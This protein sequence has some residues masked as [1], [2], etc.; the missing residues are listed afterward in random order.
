M[1]Q[2]TVVNGR[3][4]VVTGAASGIGRALAQRLAGHGCPV[5]IC[6]WDEAGLEETAASISGPVLARRLDVSDRHGTPIAPEN[7]ANLVVFDPDER[8]QVRPAALASRSRNTPF[9]GLELRGRVR[10]TVFRGE[11]VVIDGVAT[12]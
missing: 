6:D 2:A 4:A 7:P 11:P 1:A 12:R 3:T 8:W 5:A 9:V 10:H